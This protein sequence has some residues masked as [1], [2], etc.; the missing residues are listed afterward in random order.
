MKKLF[1]VVLAAAIVA[2]GLWAAFAYCLWQAD[3]DIRHVKY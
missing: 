3:N 2:A 1:K